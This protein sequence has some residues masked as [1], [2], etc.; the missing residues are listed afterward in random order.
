[1]DYRTL[2]NRYK[3]L[4]SIYF[5]DD[6]NKVILSDKEFKAMLIQ[7]KRSIIVR[8]YQESDSQT[9]FKEQFPDE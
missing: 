3:H 1:M 2:I 5:S 9:I 4:R 6:D 7:L 8:K